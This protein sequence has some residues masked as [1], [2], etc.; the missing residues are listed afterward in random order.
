VDVQI[1]DSGKVKYTFS[2]V[3]AAGQA[4][5]LPANTPALSNIVSSD[6]NLVVTADPADPTGM[7]LIGT[8]TLQP[9][10]VLPILAIVVTAQ[11]TFPGAA[12]PVTGTAAP[13]DLVAGPAAGLAVAELSE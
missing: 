6:P 8:P 9:G 10:A 12:A 2:A 5:A 1:L 4:T 7:T 11:T 13:V 3:D